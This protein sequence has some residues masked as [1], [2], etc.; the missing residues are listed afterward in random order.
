MG[1]VT[2]RPGVHIY[3]N[4]NG[5]ECNKKFTSKT[6]WEVAKSSM[7]F[8]MA[9][10]MPR[11]TLRAHSDSST[12]G[13]RCSICPSWKENTSGCCSSPAAKLADPEAIDRADPSRG[14]DCSRTTRLSWTLSNPRII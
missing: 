4:R 8:C 13:Q 7:E 14:S 3:D 10:R 12:D 11:L 2:L 5:V 1:T 6:S 9:D